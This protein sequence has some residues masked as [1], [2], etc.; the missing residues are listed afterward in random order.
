MAI[1]QR[2]V[3]STLRFMDDRALQQYAAMH[4]NDP[5]IFPLAFQES[6]NR[7]K[8]RMGQQTAQG[9]QP[10]PKVNEQALAQMA[11]QPMPEEQ[12]I[13]ALPAGNMETMADGGIAGYPDDDFVTRNQSVVMMAGGGHVPRYQG[14][15]RDGS[16]VRLPYGGDTM[17]MPTF[18]QQDLAAQASDLAIGERGRARVLA[19]LEQ[20]AAFLTS[21][22]APQ[23]EEARAQLEA[24]K[25]S[26]TVPTPKPT[27]TTSATKP[28]APFKGTMPEAGYTYKGMENDPRLNTPPSKPFAA[29]PKPDTARKDTTR[30]E[31]T[32]AAATDPSAKPD[33]GGLDTLM[34]EFERKQSLAR[35]TSR[36]ADVQY[37]SSLRGEGAKL[38]ED[39]EKRIKDQVDP[40]KDRE[41][42]LLKQEKGLEGKGDKYLGLALLEAGAA[43]MR[44]PGKFNF[45]KVVGAGIPVGS[46]RYVQG[47]EKISAAKD[48]FADARDRLDDLRLNRADM[49]ARDIKAAKT[50]AR[51]LERQAEAL[52]Y[53]G[54]KEDL[55]MTD[56]SLTTLLGLAADQLKTKDQQAFEATQTDK[57]IKSSEKIAAIGESGANARAGMLPGEAR[58]AMLLGTGSTEA[59]RFTSGMAK[60]KELTGDKQ[61]TQLL[62]LFLEENGRREKNME[63]PLTLDQF[64]RTSA[65]FYAPPAPVDTNKPTRP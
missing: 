14:N 19:E 8:I 20:K 24:F 1:D 11:P 33:T 55:K 31:P 63:K 58:A 17:G 16:L 30:K 25:S 7:Q 29:A 32:A 35:N 5:Y 15:P 39:E 36:N 65:A 4:K 60:Y 48:K 10:Q 47:M 61:G 46:A 50:E 45:G 37:A 22:G 28:N 9:M 42:R 44:T 6:Q 23:A 34:A 41:A 49:N 56:K 53:T 27:A 59:E 40:Y 62:K 38:V 21:V 52:F 18:E 57:K 64:R 26:G 43:M 12:G 51:T 3:S 54:A 13:G 2:D